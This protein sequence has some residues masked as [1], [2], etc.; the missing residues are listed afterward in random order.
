VYIRL[1]DAV[2]PIKELTYVHVLGVHC[3]LGRSMCAVCDQWKVRYV[4]TE[5]LLCGTWTRS[6]DWRLV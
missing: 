6:G 2:L 5:S 4:R 1:H 3:A